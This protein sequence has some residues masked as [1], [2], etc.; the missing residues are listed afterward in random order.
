MFQFDDLAKGLAGG[1]SRREALR[2]LGGLL[3][4]T[5]GAVLA[6]VGL[7]KARGQGPGPSTCDEYC[8]QFYPPPRG[9]AFGQCVRSCTACVRAGGIACG[10]GVDCCD[11]ATEVC[12][13]GTCEV[14]C[15]AQS[16]DPCDTS[17][18]PALCCA[19]GSACDATGSCP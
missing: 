16:G 6:S 2:R 14:A 8:A 15:T 4:V 10:P 9:E 1:L 17:G 3:G 19:D 7:G 13:D 18:D 11:P 12:I 5:A